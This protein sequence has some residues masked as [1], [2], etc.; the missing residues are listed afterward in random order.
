MQRTSRISFQPSLLTVAFATAQP[1]KTPKSLATSIRPRA[2][3]N[4]LNCERFARWHAKFVENDYFFLARKDCVLKLEL[5]LTNSIFSK[6]NVRSQVR[7]L[8]ADMTA[9]RA[10]STASDTPVARAF[11]DPD[12]LRAN[13]KHLP[14][15]VLDLTSIAECLR[16]QLSITNFLFLR[17]LKIF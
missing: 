15:Q 8:L 16:S 11:T 13:T 7:V 1:T 2:C 17:L 3:V 6:A 14:F 12:R 5:S 10:D 9:V 4:E